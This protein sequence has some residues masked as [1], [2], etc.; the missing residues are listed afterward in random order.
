MG[1]FRKSEAE[2]WAEAKLDPGRNARAGRG[3]TA[4]Q[5]VARQAKASRERNKRRSS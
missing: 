3:L 1:F 2:K 4:D 5:I